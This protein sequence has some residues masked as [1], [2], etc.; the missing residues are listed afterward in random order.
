MTQGFPDFIRALPEP[1]SPV[2][3]RAH[4][5]VSDSCLPMFYEI[6]DDVE[7]PEH[8]HGAQWGVVLQGEME[9]V[10]G[11]ESTIYRRGDTYLVPAGVTH[12]TRIKGGYRGIDVFADP[13]RYLPKAAE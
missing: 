2:D 13:D 4:I 9:M 6:D 7:V 1:D 3:M 11:G 8:V 12:I 5:A 10:I